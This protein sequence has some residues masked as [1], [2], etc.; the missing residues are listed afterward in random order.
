VRLNDPRRTPPTSDGFISKYT[1]LGT[2]VVQ[3]RRNIDFL[4]ETLHIL[5][6]LLLCLLSLHL[7]TPETLQSP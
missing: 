7:I 2:V 4:I 6:A 3:F 5:L 1:I